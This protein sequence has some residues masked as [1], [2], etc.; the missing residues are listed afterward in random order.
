MLPIAILAG[1]LAT[2]LQPKTLT[3]PKAMIEVAGEPFICHQLRYLRQQ[4]IDEVVICIGHLGQI[5]QDRIRN[6]S[7][8]GLNVRYSLDGPKLLGTAGALKQALPLLDDKF[9][10]VYGDTFLPIN[11][12]EVQQSYFASHKPALMTILKNGDKWDKSNVVYRNHQLEEYNKSESRP[13][14][15]YIDYGLA[16]LSREIFE[17]V[18]LGEKIDLADVYQQLSKDG[19]LAGYEV[20]E[21]FY[22]IG[23]FDGLSEADNYITKLYQESKR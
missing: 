11:F 14:M 2:R 9:F 16:V 19:Q 8:F 6:G 10:V 4:G 13:E 22:E 7:E 21:R 1:G 15:N 23:S 17:T 12:K 18:P 20:H 5:I 3:I